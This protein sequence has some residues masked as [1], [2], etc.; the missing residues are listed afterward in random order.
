M[1]NGSTGRVVGGARVALA[2]LA[3][4][5]VRPAATDPA[6]AA[7]IAAAECCTAFERGVLDE[8]N[9]ARTDPTLVA[10]ELEARLPNYRG[11]IYRAPAA[12]VGVRTVEGASAVREAVRVLRATRPLTALRFSR[13][14]SA[15]AADHVRD[16]GPRGG[17]GHQG[18]DRSVPA[19]RASRYGRWFGIVSEN[20]QYGRT[21]TARDVVA[22]LLVDDGVPDRG[23]RRNMLDPLVRVAGVAC[24]PHA[25]YGQMCVILHA[26]DYAEAPT[27]R[28]SR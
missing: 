16:Q 23:H 21:A 8:I 10:A 26:A 14:L 3:L 28:P 11:N 9:R 22:D 2:V 19:T 5:C 27:S 24:G 15:G 4:G 25:N 17:L 7:P 1:T 13:G 6:V 12:D 18:T 20:I